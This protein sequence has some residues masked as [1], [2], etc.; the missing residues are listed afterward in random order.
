MSKPEF[1]VIQGWY[2][3]KITIAPIGG[4]TMCDIGKTDWNR[5]YKNKTKNANEYPVE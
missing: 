3:G 4:G 5:I 1:T 2:N